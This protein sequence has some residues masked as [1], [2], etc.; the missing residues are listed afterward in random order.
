MQ[1][2]N[3]ATYNNRFATGNILIEDLTISEL[4]E[5]TCVFGLND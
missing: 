2:K 5:L 1:S 4:T 3:S